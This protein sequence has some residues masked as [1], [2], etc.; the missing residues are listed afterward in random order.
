MFNRTQMAIGQAR[1]LAEENTELRRLLA[2]LGQIGDYGS[3]NDPAELVHSSQVTQGAHVRP[4]AHQLPV[5]ASEDQLG[6][7]IAA[8]G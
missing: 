5:P 4:L 1:C 3:A 2:K 7:H 6:A 8:A